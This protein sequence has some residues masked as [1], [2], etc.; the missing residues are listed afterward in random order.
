MVNIYLD[1]YDDTR[2][3]LIIGEI[4][5]ENNEK[6][7]LGAI[8]ELGILDSL[9]VIEKRFIRQ[10]NSQNLKYENFIVYE[11]KKNGYF[12]LYQLLSTTV[13]I[14]DFSTIIK[15]MQ[16]NQVLSVND[17]YFDNQNVGILKKANNRNFKIQNFDNYQLGNESEFE[18]RDLVSVDLASSQ[19]KNYNLWFNKQR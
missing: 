12:D 8:D 13:E 4:I 7:L 1:Y 2:E 14:L 17:Y 11:S 16:I 5:Q 15:G 18:Y 9:T 3:N 10:I 6:I 19:I